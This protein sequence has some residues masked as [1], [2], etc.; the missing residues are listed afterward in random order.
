MSSIYQLHFPN[1]SPLSGCTLEWIS[2][3]STWQDHGSDQPVYLTK[4]S[5][6]PST[7]TSVSGVVAGD[8]IR[9]WKA[10]GIQRGDFIHPSGNLDVVNTQILEQSDTFGIGAG[11]Y[12]KCISTTV[13]GSGGGTSTEGVPTVE[14]EAFFSKDPGSDY[15]RW[16]VTGLNTDSTDY[17]YLYDYMPTLTST[18]SAIGQRTFPASS[19]S[20][21]QYGLFTP[22]ITKTYYVINYDGTSS[23]TNLGAV[24]LASKNFAAKKKVFCNF[25]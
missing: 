10:G 13:S 24:V 22:D 5:T 25:W 17:I 23:S 20:S 9:G 6:S 11:G 1:G 18:V 7:T 2:S 14:W 19:S 4:N 12:W 16:T 8:R 3:S 15:W 21:T